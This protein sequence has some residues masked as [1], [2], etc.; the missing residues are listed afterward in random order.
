M[1]LIVKNAVRCLSCD[2]IVESKTRYDMIYS[3]VVVGTFLLMAD[4]II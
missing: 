2:D 4:M 1:I 3:H